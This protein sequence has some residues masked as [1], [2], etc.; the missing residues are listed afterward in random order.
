MTAEVIELTIERGKTFEWAF[1]YADDVLTYKA[2]S[3]MPSAAPVRLTVA[4][5][6]IPD[7]WPVEVIGVKNPAELNTKADMPR[8]CRVIDADTIEFNTLYG[9]DWRAYA[10]GGHVVFNTPADL[11]GW[12]ARA[13]VYDKVGGTKL[14]SWHS[15][16]LTAPDCPLTIDTAAS[17]FVLHMDA[18]M[19][20]GLP[21]S[22][23]LWEMEAIDPAGKVYPVVAISP[24]IVTKEALI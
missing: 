12:T 5:H 7:G 13:A 24:V 18:A 20:A 19:A 9:A 8:L 11:T 16:P 6:G 4:A 2:I 21:W 23:G 22:K 10:S 17:A 14:L 1:Q 3:A 15:D